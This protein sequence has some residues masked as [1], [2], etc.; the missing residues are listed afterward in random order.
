MAES[1]RMGDRSAIMS[2]Q[3]SLNIFG[4]H[5]P[6]IQT[7]TRLEWHVKCTKKC[8]VPVHACMYIDL[9]WFFSMAQ[10]QCSH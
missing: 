8:D 3:K 5:F 10:R 2:H 7:L 4:K 9:V 1:E 6:S